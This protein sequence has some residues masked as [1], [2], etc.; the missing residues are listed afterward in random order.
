MIPTQGAGLLGANAYQQAQRDVRVPAGPLRR[1]SKA[2]A[3]SRVKLFD[4]RPV[5]PRGGFTKAA[6]LRPTRSLDSACRMAR[7]SELRVIWSERVE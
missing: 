5:R 4:G 6:T 3:W 1:V 2:F 7:S